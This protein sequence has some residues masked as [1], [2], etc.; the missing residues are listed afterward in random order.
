MFRDACMKD[1]PSCC[2]FRLP[3]NI[4]RYMWKLR[5]LPL[6]MRQVY[7]QETRG[8]TGSPKFQIMQTLPGGT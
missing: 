8:G 3:S 6:C 4:S 5:S 1:L 2:P 7:I